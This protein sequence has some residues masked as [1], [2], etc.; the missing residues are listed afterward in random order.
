M[1]DTDLNNYVRLHSFHFGYKVNSLATNFGR[2]DSFFLLVC[3]FSCLIRNARPFHW[4]TNKH[5]R[6]PS[7]LKSIVFGSEF[8]HGVQG[9]VWPRGGL[10]LLTFSEGFSRQPL[11]S[12][13]WPDTIEEFNLECINIR[14]LRQVRWPRALKRLKLDLGLQRIQA[15][16]WPV[17]LEELEFGERFNQRIDGVRWPMGLRRLAFG[18]SFNR[19][20]DGV[21]WPIALR[22]LR[23]GCMFNQPLQ[24]VSWPRELKRLS[25]RDHFDQSVCGVRWSRGLEELSFGGWAF[26]QPLGRDVAWPTALKKLTLGRSFLDEHP[27]ASVALPVGLVELEVAEE[28]KRCL[29]GIRWPRGLRV[30]TA[31]RAAIGEDEL[32][33]R[34]PAG[35]RIRR[36][37]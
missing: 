11:D 7:E 36:K 9:T 26:K 20:L 28:C 14:A 5:P 4:E 12:V 35:C 18:R 2:N 32:Q 34:L 13:A 29:N 1:P 22:E 37:R 16:T 17:T 10:K 24:R 3:V 8:S 25:F 27:P 21:M 33:L 31:G 19:P 30:L 23:F 6:W 15:I